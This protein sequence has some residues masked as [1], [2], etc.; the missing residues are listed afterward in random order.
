MTEAL[1]TSRPTSTTEV[2]SNTWASVGGEGG[3]DFLLLA[4]GQAAMQQ[5]DA[6]RCEDFFQMVKFL[7]DGF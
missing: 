4:A 6:G 5:P 1:G 3:H 2:A 7:G